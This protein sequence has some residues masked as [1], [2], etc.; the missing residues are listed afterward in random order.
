LCVCLIEVFVKLAAFFSV[1]V[2]KQFRDL[3]TLGAIACCIR[4]SGGDRSA[5]VIDNPVIAGDDVAEAGPG[6]GHHVASDDDIL[7]HIILSEYYTVV[8]H[9]TQQT[10]KKLGKRIS[11]AQHG[12]IKFNHD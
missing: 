2:G 10:N 4:L 8:H 11:W 6:R 7:I 12:K 9:L 1:L 3:A 5:R